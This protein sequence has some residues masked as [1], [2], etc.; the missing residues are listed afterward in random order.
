MIKLNSKK[1]IIHKMI[2]TISGKQGAG[3]TSV[4]KILSGKLGYD[5]ISIGNLHREIAVER[6]MTIN[7]LMELGKKEDWVHLEADKKTIEIGKTRDSFIIE[8]WLAYH[9]IPHSYKVFLSVNENVGAKRIFKDVRIDEPRAE[10][11][12]TTK[13]RLRKRLKNSQEG[14][15]KHYNLDFL[16]QSNYDFVLDTTHLTLNQVVK[17]IEEEIKKIV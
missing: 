2:I 10:T 12:E 13:Q 3:K 4:S 14:F 11:I 5:L 1:N 6:G 8:G 7:E 16:D 9:F 15:K 17:K